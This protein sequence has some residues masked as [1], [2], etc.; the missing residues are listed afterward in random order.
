MGT[1]PREAPGLDAGS[2]VNAPGKRGIGDARSQG[3]DPQGPIFDSYP[4]Q[5]IV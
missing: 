4:R 2:V 1:S 3:P 5:G